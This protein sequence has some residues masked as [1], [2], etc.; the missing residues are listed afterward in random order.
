MINLTGFAGI[1][2]LASFL[3]ECGHIRDKDDDIPFQTNVSEISAWKHASDDFAQ[4]LPN[5]EERLEFYNIVRESLAT[6]NVGDRVVKE[7]FQAL[8]TLAE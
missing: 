3:H 7:T 6:Y 2:L 8:I 1:P 4:L 5:T